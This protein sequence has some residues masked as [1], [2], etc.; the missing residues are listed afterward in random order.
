MPIQIEIPGF[1]TVEMD[2]KTFIA[3]GEHR[4]YAQLLSIDV[5]QTG[6]SVGVCQYGEYQHF[7]KSAAIRHAKLEG[8]RIPDT[9]EF[10]SMIQ[11]VDPESC[12]KRLK[13]RIT[14][15]YAGFSTENQ[16]YEDDVSRFW[17]SEVNDVASNVFAIDRRTT[18]LRSYA[19]S[20]AFFHPVL[21]FK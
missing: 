6:R 10:L 7:N 14:I 21:C 9:I 19:I 12:G 11:Q 18:N 2:G 5:A 3:V 8:L 4:V 13:G 17:S 15:P 16:S 1:P 20:N